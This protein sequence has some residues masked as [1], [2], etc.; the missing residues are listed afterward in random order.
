MDMNKRNT[1]KGEAMP[2]P[3]TEPLYIIGVQQDKM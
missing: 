1:K 2:L 3:I